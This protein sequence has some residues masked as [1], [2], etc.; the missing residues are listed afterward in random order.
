MPMS[1][2]WDCLQNRQHPT[3]RQPTIAPLPSHHRPAR[4]T[5]SNPSSNIIGNIIGKHSGNAIGKIGNAPR[6]L[7]FT[8]PAALATRIPGKNQPSRQPPHHNH[9]SGNITG[10]N[11]GKK[12]ANIPATCSAITYPATGRCFTHPTS[13]RV[14]GCR[15]P[16]G[17]CGAKRQ[18]LAGHRPRLQPLATLPAIPPAKNRQRSGNDS[19]NHIRRLQPRHT[20]PPRAGERSHVA[21]PH[22]NT[23]CYLSDSAAADE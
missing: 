2:N 7:P 9:R 18:L 5:P 19:G 13:T 15:A 16:V 8:T 4:H 1:S 14:I 21:P 3:H 23:L 6:L 20:S 11:S 17:F 10:N 22:P 12:S